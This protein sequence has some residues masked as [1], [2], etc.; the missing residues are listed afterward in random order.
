MTLLDRARNIRNQ[1]EQA[2]QY[3]PDDVAVNSIDLYPKWGESTNYTVGSRVRYGD[4]LYRCLQEHFWQFDWTPFDAVSLWA[5]V[6]TSDD[7]T[8]LPWEQPDSTNPYQIGD[9]VTHN[10]ITWESIVADNV[11]EP[12]VY[13]WIEVE[14][15]EGDAAGDSS[16]SGEDDNSGSGDESGS[17]SGGS[18]DDGSA[19]GS[20]ASDAEESDGNDNSDIAEWEQRYGHNPYMTGD[21]VLF[22]GSVYEC[23]YDGNTFSPE[24]FPLGWKLIS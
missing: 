4:N 9:Q 15:E 22:N 21:K 6:L 16:S 24:T 18:G 10:G 1:T 12:G 14:D 17:E 3:L 8:V 5:K 7:G 11:W 13:G 23:V 19:D 20:D 2:A